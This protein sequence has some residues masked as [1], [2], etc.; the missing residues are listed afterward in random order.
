[1]IDSIRRHIALGNWAALILVGG[2]GLWASTMQIAGAVIAPGVLVVSSNVKN[3]QHLEG[4]IVRE[5]FVDDGDIVEKGQTL[6]RLNESDAEADLQSLGDQIK[7]LE[8]ENEALKTQLPSIEEQ[9]KDMEGLFKKGFARKAEF[10]ELKRT[11][12][13]VKGDI[14]SNESKLS[15]LHEQEKKAL[16]KVNRNVIVS[17]QDGMIMGLKIHTPGGV[18]T[19]AEVIMMIVP[20]NDN[21]DVE[22]RI[23]PRM[24]DQVKIGQ[25]ASMRFTAFNQRTTPEIDGT[26]TKISPDLI[27][28]PKQ[29]TS[30][31]AVRITVQK[32][33]IKDLALN[34]VPGM[35]VESF[36][37][38]DSRTLVSYLMKPL[39][40]Q[41]NKAFRER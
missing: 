16:A 35:P 30:Y 17:P 18:I 33:R 27:E 41:V 22:A 6:I 11:Q 23:E 8:S 7:A 24:I 25:N 32:E 9:L 28:D 4:G 14:A 3:I 1:M 20:Q 38:T 21:L 13:R 40:D 37:L 2:I 12:V 26:V 5:I 19:P 29:N 34:L 31:Y 36:I 15:S 10:Y 39:F